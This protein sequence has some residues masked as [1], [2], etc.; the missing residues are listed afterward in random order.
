MRARGHDRRIG[1]EPAGIGGDGVAIQRRRDIGHL[2][3]G[4]DIHAGLLAGLLGERIRRLT[5]VDDVAVGRLESQQV[6]VGIAALDDFRLNVGDLVA[7]DGAEF[8]EE[9]AESLVVVAGFQ[10]GDFVVTDRQHHLAALGVHL[11]VGVVIFE[12]TC[13]QLRALLDLL[14][15]FER[16]VGLDIAEVQR[17]GV[18]RAVGVDRAELGLLFDQ[19]N[20]VDVGELR[21]RVQQRGTADAAAGDHEVVFA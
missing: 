21:G 15:L 14:G 7:L 1:I 18:V 8:R 4:V 5:V 6:L 11:A 19:C 16:V 13:E 3:V 9:V 20:R 10:L 12:V 17:L 2:G